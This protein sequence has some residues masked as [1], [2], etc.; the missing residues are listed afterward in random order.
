M[1]TTLAQAV[2]HHHQSQADAAEKGYRAWL[3]DHPKDANTWHLLGILYGQLEQY[4][5]ALNALKQ[6]LRYAPHRETFHNSL[7]N[8]YKHLGKTQQAIEHLNTALT[9]NPN[10]ALLI[11]NL[12]TIYAHSGNHR[13]AL[14]YY[15]QALEHD[16][17]YL[18]AHINN[19]LS[20]LHLNH[21]ESAQTAF[22]T[23]L[24]HD[25]KHAIAHHQLGQIFH[26]NQQF[27]HALS[28]YQQA[29]AQR[30]K[31]ALSHHQIACIHC[32]LGNSTLA[33]QSFL[34][35]LE[36]APDHHESH[37]NLAALYTQSHQ[38]KLALPHWLRALETHLDAETL[39]NVGAT[40]LALN[41]SLE[42]KP[43]LL[44]ALAHNSDHSDTH[45]AL[46]AVYLK[47][48][49]QQ[50]AIL[51]YRTALS[52]DATLDDV[53]YVL[54]AIEDQPTQYDRTP[55]TYIK[56]L[57]NQYAERFDR[58]LI[59]EL[60]YQTPHILATQLADYM[61]KSSFRFALDLGCGTGLAAK[62][63]QHLAQHFTGVDLSEGMLAQAKK[64]GLY[65]HLI[66]TEVIAYLERTET[67][68]V[69]LIL[70]AD[71]LP[72]FGDCSRLL[73]AISNRLAPKGILALS[74]ERLNTSTPF[75]L[76]TCARYAHS[77]THLK[78]CLDQANLLLENTAPVTLR[79]QDEK[80]VPGQWLIA[81]KPAI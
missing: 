9:L 24:K 60:A 40:Y 75:Q 27:E 70:A 77:P 50:Q 76:Q 63:C 47:S 65:Q 8:V 46:G 29:L 52:L 21:L 10:S 5:D 17:E 68:P 72:Y 28:H 66:C 37:H 80:P 49:E 31:H 18:D 19:G 2:A 62:A 61:P 3:K 22:E 71:V 33:I 64:T 43:Y 23:V 38:Y 51:H 20:H 30:P 1:T 35:A 56:N 44:D 13:S 53:R 25:P 58:H 73:Q 42:A 54:N 34:S 41:Q 81:R 11:N 16:P 67:E 4:Q 26:Q 32:Q 74:Y 78:N 6:A 79:Q 48:N 14:A 59:G 45:I 55:D 36:H 39:Y 12:G 15:H 69:D 7:G 57:F